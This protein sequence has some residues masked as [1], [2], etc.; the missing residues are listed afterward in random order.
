MVGAAETHSYAPWR[1]EALPSLHSISQLTVSETII[2]FEGSPQGLSI[3]P[4]KFI[5]YSVVESRVQPGIRKS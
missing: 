4:M 5:S 1:V 3:V 2:A